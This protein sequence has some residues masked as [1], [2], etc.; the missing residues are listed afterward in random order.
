MGRKRLTVG[1]LFSGIGGFDAGFDAAGFRT[2]WQV[3]IDPAARR[4]L[5]RHFP[6]VKRFEDVKGVG[7]HNLARVDVVCFGSPCQDLSVAGKRGGLAG[8]RSGLFHEAIRIVRELRPALVVFENVPGL[9]SSN[10][11]R[12]FATVLREFWDGGARDLCWRIL[13][14]Q[15]FG[16]AQ[17]RKR[18]FLVAD[19]AGERAGPILLEPACRCGHPPPRGQAEQGVAA[20]VTPGARRA[21]GNRGGEQLHVAAPL[22]AGQTTGEGVNRPGRRREDDV[23]LVTAPALQA[24][25]HKGV[26]GH[27][28][29]RTADDLLVTGTLNY[30]NGKGGFRTEPGEHLV[31]HT[32]RSESADAGE[33][34]TGTPPVVVPADPAAYQC[35][36]NNVG[37]LG[38]LRQGNGGL[39]GGVPFIRGAMTVRRLTPAE[40]ERL[41]GFTDGWLDLDPPLSDSTKYRL[42]GNACAVPVA[43]WIAN[44]VMEALHGKP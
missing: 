42:L 39:T 24:R 10:S 41:Q 23:N 36:G 12:D 6:G 33:D 18:V 26:N 44:R 35:H 16:L 9:L 34:G 1:S 29:G 27:W 8:E 43:A 38:T 3:E 25:S 21:S 17:R 37:P 22:T 20:S 13:D 40:C 5:A 32:P 2:L 15:Y 14:A 30:G 31:A 11:G 7:K 19:F 4:V 28:S